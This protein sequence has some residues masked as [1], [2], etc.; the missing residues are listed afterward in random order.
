VPVLGVLALQPDALGWGTQPE[1]VVPYLP[2]GARFEP[3]DDLGHFLHIEAPHR[4]ADLVLEF[5]S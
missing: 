2:P 3:M 1:D 4:I 5:L